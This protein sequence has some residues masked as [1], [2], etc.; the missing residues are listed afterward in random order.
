[1]SSFLKLDN[2][3]ATPRIQST[4]QVMYKVQVTSSTCLTYLTRIAGL[5]SND[6][7]YINKVDPTENTQATI[8]RSDRGFLSFR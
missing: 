7:G 5:S 3:G 8:A 4:Y 6:M 2:D 1:V